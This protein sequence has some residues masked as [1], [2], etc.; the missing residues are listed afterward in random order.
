MSN[1]DSLTPLKA[2]ALLGAPALL[3][4]ALYFPSLDYEFVW[5]DIPEI[6]EGNLILPEYD[7]VNAFFRPLH[8]TQSGR[9]NTS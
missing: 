5:M 3:L 4:I 7:Y 6:K 2:L 8:V 9:S 1:T